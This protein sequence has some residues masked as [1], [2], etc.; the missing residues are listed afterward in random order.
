MCKGE[1]NKV[2]GETHEEVEEYE[3]RRE[4]ETI[5]GLGQ[6]QTPDHRFKERWVFVRRKLG[7][8]NDQESVNAI[9]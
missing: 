3:R 5:Y 1:K 2:K 6:V 4:K 7:G 9:L 8:R